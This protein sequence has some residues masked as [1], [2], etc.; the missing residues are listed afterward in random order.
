MKPGVLLPFFA[1]LAL[2][3][4][5]TAWCKD[6]GGYTS[7]LRHQ[8]DHAV[9]VALMSHPSDFCQDLTSAQRGEGFIFSSVHLLYVVCVTQSYSDSEKLKNHFYLS[10]SFQF[11]LVPVMIISISQRELVHRL[12]AN[13]YLTIYPTLSD[14][15]DVKLCLCFWLGGKAIIFSPTQLLLYHQWEKHG[16]WREGRVLMEVTSNPEV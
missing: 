1:A 3:S 7:M 14:T 6:A 13:A 9:V 8:Q 11:L 16:T 5:Y 15:E 12:C 10:C 4:I 2:L